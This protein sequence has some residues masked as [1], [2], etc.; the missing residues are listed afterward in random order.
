MK[1]ILESIAA[2]YGKTWDTMGV[3]ELTDVLRKLCKGS[4]CTAKCEDCKW[5]GYLSVAPNET[6]TACFYILLTGHSRPCPAGDHCT[7]YEPGRERR[8][9]HPFEPWYYKC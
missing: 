9:P 3:E 6:N 7:V 8:R 5:A 4:V 2:L 1:V